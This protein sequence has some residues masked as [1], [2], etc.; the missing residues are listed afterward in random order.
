MYT[1][2]IRAPDAR[3]AGRGNAGFTL[4][5]IM[6]ALVLAS[7]F[8]GIIFQLIRGQGRF[9]EVQ[10]ARQEVQQNARA[11]VEV[12]GSELRGATAQGLLRGED[13][14]IEYMA[15]R[16]FGLTC[17]NGTSTQ[18][19]VIAPVVDASALTVGSS[20]GLMVD[21]AGDPRTYSPA[22]G[23]RARVTAMAGVN[24]AT[25]NCAGMGPAGPA[26]VYR[27]TGTNFP[28]VPAGRSI[29]TYDIVRYDVAADD[30]GLPWVRRGNTVAGGQQPFVGP[31][32]SSTALRFRYFTA[33]SSVPMTAPGTTVANL[34]QVNRVR[35]VISARSKGPTSATRQIE[36]DSVT[37]FLRNR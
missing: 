16:F 23:T 17:P 22:T 35:V 1:S 21:I 28:V 8:A 36:R 37:I 15:P 9:V 30:G 26:T 25:S 7:V 29:F 19:D 33:G 20:T 3:R 6:V 24:L 13:G 32:E 27:L 5:E 10:S 34:R 18:V 2:M 11:A 4:V 12:I 14:V 31:L